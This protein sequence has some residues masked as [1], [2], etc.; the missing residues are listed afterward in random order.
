MA[1]I[2]ILDTHSCGS[3]L[4]VVYHGGYSQRI[5]RLRTIDPHIRVPVKGQVCAG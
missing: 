3:T 5:H 2:L 4:P 1:V